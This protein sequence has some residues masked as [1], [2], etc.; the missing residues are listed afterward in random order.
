MR[1]ES[2]PIYAGLQMGLKDAERNQS[3]KRSRTGL[4]KG[5]SRLTP[6]DQLPSKREEPGAKTGQNKS[7]RG[8]WK[9]IM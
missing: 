1:R 7:R 8:E 5:G 4:L 3:G 9:S 2:E 6:L